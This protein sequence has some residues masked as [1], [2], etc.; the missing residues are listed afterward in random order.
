MPVIKVSTALAA[1]GDQ[2]FP[3]NRNQYEILP[4]D[5][6]VEFAITTDIAITRASV[7]SGGDLLQQSSDLDVLAAANPHLYP[8]HYTLN[9][10]AGRSERL[11]VELTKISGAAS[12]TRTSVRITRV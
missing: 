9:D 2:A 10:V 7:Y 5:A 12:V 11:G 6:L 3:L 1:A 4:Y 8:D